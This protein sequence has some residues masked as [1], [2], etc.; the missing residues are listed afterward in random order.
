MRKF[1]LV[2]LALTAT[3]AIASKAR[4]DSFDYTI[5]GQY[6][7]A[8]LTFTASPIAGY[9]GDY[10]ITG[11]TGWFSDLGTDGT[12][13]L[14]SS[15]PAT[16]IPADGA[17]PASG[18]NPTTYADNGLFLYDNVLYANQTGNGILDW[19]G[20]LFS[21]NSGY[22]LNIFSDSN[23]SG[24]GYFYW[25]DSGDNHSN[26]PI[27]IGPS[28]DPIAA[29]ENLAATPEPGSLFLLGTGFLGLAAVVVLKG[30][31]SGLDPNS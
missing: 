22:E 6:F 10:T 21:L 18:G 2:L 19:G 16:V 14:S 17:T 20:L 15:N 31:P 30:K 23:A 28:D 1:P 25:A 9:P 12:V 27:T 4:A 8:D 13:T 3:F 5:S 29:P 7:S 24:A 26:N 11:V